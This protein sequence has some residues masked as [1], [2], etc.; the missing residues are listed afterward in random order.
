MF[1][2][3]SRDP[4]LSALLTKAARLQQLEAHLR[5]ALPPELAARVRV[6]DLRDGLLVLS[7]PTPAAASRLRYAKPGIVKA[8]GG[9]CSKEEVREVKVR[10]LT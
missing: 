9:E 1:E 5:R 2:V 8:L 10:V 4:H 3:A 7:A 6:A